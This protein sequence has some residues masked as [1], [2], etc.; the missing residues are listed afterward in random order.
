ML[1]RAAFE[2]AV[3]RVIPR[4]ERAEFINAGALVI[5]RAARFLEGRIAFDPAR[6]RAIAPNVSD[7]M[8]IDLERQLSVIPRICAGDRSAGPIAELNIGQRWHWLTAPASTIVQVS[9]VHTG[10]TS[11]P[12]ATLER[13]FQRLV[14][15]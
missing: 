14:L 7:D 10:F 9:P 13:L 8:L 4:I 5:C 3:V 12:G 2:Y 1:E 11:D 6:L 15:D